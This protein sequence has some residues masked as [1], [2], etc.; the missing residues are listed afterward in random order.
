MTIHT[1]TSEPAIRR[2]IKAV[3]VGKKG[4]KP[5]DENLIDELI[6]DFKEDRVTPIE[7]GAFFGALVMKGIT[8]AEQKLE[9]II[10]HNAFSDFKKMVGAIATDAPDMIQWVCE[11]LL[12]GSTL[13]KQTTYKVGQFL[14]SD[15]KGE[16]ARGMIASILRV[17]YETD[18]E[19]EGLLQAVHET[20]KPEFRHAVP[21]GKPII[22]I[23]EPF[24]GCDHSNMITPLVARNLQDLGY[25]VVTLCGRNSG[26]KFGNNIY[27]IAQQLKGDFL[28][29]SAALSDEPKA[30][31]W[32]LKQKDL[33]DALDQWVDRRHKIIKR[34]FLATI[35]RFVNPLTADICI[36]SAF[37]PPYG[38]K[39]LTMAERMGFKG[40]IIVR[41]GLEGT[42]AFPLLR[43][44]KILCS[45]RQA[46]GTYLRHEFEYNVQE[47]LGIKPDIEEKLINPSVE[48]NVALINEFVDNGQTSY[49]LFNGRVK[50]TSEGIKCAIKWIK[51]N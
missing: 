39:M 1:T 45:A 8:P 31:G 11:K 34:P 17:R 25:R 50:A 26:P 41:N 18:E 36:A 13:D 44:A 19:Y 23:A 10:A 14:F 16:G 2:A 29:K 33:S 21:A 46:D 7:R 28:G 5:L 30:F 9:S 3:A 35:E 32:F 40:N 49:D 6:N 27:D 37:H 12:S 42:V 47:E 22:Q 4:S 51:E 43:S 20:I 24:D 48:K 38:E 15:E